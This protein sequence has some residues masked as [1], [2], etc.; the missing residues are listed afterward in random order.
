[1]YYE[2]FNVIVM[3]H[4]FCLDIT[5][6]SVVQKKLILLLLDMKGN[7]FDILILKFFDVFVENV[8]ILT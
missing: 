1:M 8:S 5:Y 3:I 7:F 2:I 6:Y 4:F